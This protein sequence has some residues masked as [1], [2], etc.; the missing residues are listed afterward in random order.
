M[1][2]SSTHDLWLFI[3]IPS[4]KHFFPKKSIETVLLAKNVYALNKRAY[5][6]AIM[7]GAVASGGECE[8]DWVTQSKFQFDL[9]IDGAKNESAWREVAAYESTQTIFFCNRW[10]KQTNK[11]PIHASKLKLSK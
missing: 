6:T 2:Q 8:L 5:N 9:M 10:H 3:F 1:K 4:F 11:T 7:A